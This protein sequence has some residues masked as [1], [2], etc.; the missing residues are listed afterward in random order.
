MHVWK[1]KKITAGAVS[2]RKDL[3]T[4]K[5]FR[6]ENSR[7]DHSTRNDI[8]IV[9]RDAQLAALPSQS[10]PIV[11]TKLFHG[12]SSINSSVILRESNPKI[13]T[14]KLSSH[15]I[16]YPL[17]P[18]KTPPRPFQTCPKIG[19]SS[20]ILPPPPHLMLDFTSTWRDAKPL[21]LLAEKPISGRG[22]RTRLDM[23]RRV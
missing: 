13:H 19:D 8:Y 11:T 20:D 4:G 22:G 10:S 15:Y 2:N 12:P 18:P 1:K 14:K 17:P 16:S 6:E 5:I 21:F 9:Y 3:L 23:I 7:N